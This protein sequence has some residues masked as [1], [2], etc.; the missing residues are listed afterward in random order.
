MAIP[1]I[2]VY[3]CKHN[4]PVKNNITVKS[5]DEVKYNI[6]AIPVHWI[7]SRSLQLLPKAGLSLIGSTPST[8]ADEV[9]LNS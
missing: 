6:M 7:V 3:G 8:G 5:Y 4:Q 1:V 9:R 2:P